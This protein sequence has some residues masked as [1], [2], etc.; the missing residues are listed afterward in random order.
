MEKK[1]GNCVHFGDVDGEYGACKRL[2]M[3]VSKDDTC[4]LFTADVDERDKGC[5]S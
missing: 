5:E 3:H 1:C 2:Y 4:G